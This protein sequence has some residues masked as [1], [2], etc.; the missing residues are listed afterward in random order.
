MKFNKTRVLWSIILLIL[1][2]GLFLSVF[3]PQISP[4]FGIAVWKWFLGAALLYWI[5]G[6][7]IFGKTLAKHFDV[8][9]PLGLGFILF[10]SD[11]ER[12]SGTDLNYVNN[13]AILGISILL[14]IAVYLLFNNKKSTFKTTSSSKT[15]NQAQVKSSFKQGIVY[16]DL[17]DNT[18]FSVSNRM[19]ET[20]VFFQNSELG[21]Q[22]QPIRLDLS[23]DFGELTVHVP[24]NWKITSHVDNSFG[25][26]CVRPNPT[27]FSRE[28][29]LYGSNRFGETQIISCDDID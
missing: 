15:R 14:T 26:L 10:K 11:I 23:N 24:A 2:T 12:L 1:A 17:S 3:F 4:F 25:E 7:A 8:F 29:V 9:L 13:W 22:S 18:N 6:H 27:N 19:G 28:L 20:T 5:I 16:F 21:D